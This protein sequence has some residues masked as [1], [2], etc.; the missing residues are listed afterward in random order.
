VSLSPVVTSATIWPIA[1]ALDDDDDDDE[2]GS[3][4]GMSGMGN[5]SIGENL[6]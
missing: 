1:L 4:G 6:L 3:L 5:G 2:C